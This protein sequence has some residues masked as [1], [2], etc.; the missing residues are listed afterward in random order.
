MK[1]IQKAQKLS[2]ITDEKERRDELLV[3]MFDDIADSNLWLGR[4][5]DRMLSAGTSV[6]PNSVDWDFLSRFVVTEECI[7]K[8]AQSVGTVTSTETWYEWIE[9]LTVHMRHP[10]GFTQCF[11]GWSFEPYWVAAFQERAHLMNFPAG[12]MLSDYVLLHS[13][14]EYEGTVSEVSK[15]VKEEAGQHG[16]PHNNISHAL[17]PPSPHPRPPHLR[18]PL[19]KKMQPSMANVPNSRLLNEAGAALSVLK[20][21]PSARMKSSRGGG[22]NFFLDAG[23]STFDSALFWFVC[24]YLQNNIRFDAIYGW[25]MT[26]LEPN[27]FWTRVPKFLMPYYHFFNTPISAQTD[28]AQSVMRIIKQIASEEDFVSLKLDVDTPEVEIPIVQDLVA[29]EALH[30]L[31]DEFFFELHFRCEIMMYC[32]WRDKMP[33]EH[34][35]LKLDR[36]HALQLFTTLRQKG[37]R[38]HVWP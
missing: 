1:H 6:Q 16:Y 38:A 32:G 33:V 31:V 23:T 34:N 29:D 22:R 3:F 14:H 13:H 25:E 12:L 8:D 17:K 37:I 21:E 10:F 36:P 18:H 35:G 5:R 11:H 20:N 26:L 19:P 15:P 30:R 7:T 24:G 2:T 9:P 4:I 27:N 28:D